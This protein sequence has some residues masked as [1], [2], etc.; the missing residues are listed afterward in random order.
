MNVKFNRQ[1]CLE[2]VLKWISNDNIT[3]YMAQHQKDANA[4]E[5]LQYFQNVINWVEN[6]F[7]KYFSDMK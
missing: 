3:D 5:L 7:P 4:S 2:K 1:G 6:I